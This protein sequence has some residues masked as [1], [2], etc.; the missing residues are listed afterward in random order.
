M[1]CILRLFYEILLGSEQLQSIIIHFKVG[2]KLFS[3]LFK[4]L[5]DNNLFFMQFCVLKIKVA[6][7]TYEYMITNLPLDFNRESHKSVNIIKLMMKY[8]HAVKTEFRQFARPLR[9]IYAPHREQL[10]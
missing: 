9:G 8:V 10:G 5:C 4:M 7:N 3:S 6:E 1:L 2:V